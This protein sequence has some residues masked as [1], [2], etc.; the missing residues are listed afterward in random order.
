MGQVVA[1]L[2]FDF[3]AVL[4]TYEVLVLLLLLDEES[5]SARMGVMLL[6]NVVKMERSARVGR[7]RRRLR[8]RLLLLAASARLSLER[9]TVMERLI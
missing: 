1:P 6:M 9:H 5:S 3:D 4:L 7:A 8:L 2:A